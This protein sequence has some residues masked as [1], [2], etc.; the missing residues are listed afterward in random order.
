MLY[1]AADNEDEQDE[2]EESG[3]N[4]S[5]DTPEE[6]QSPAPIDTGSPQPAPPLNP[7]VAS[8]LQQIQQAH[9]QRLKNEQASDLTAALAQLTHGLSR[10]PGS[11]DL[12]GAQALAKS[13]DDPIK[14]V[15]ENHQ[16]SQY[17][18]NS[19]ESVAFRNT[20]KANFPKIAQAYGDQFDGLTASDAPQI[21][22]FAELKDTL[23]QRGQ[24]AKDRLASIEVQKQANALR[25]Q[26]IQSEKMS[27]QDE[28]TQAK[29][30]GELNSLTASGRNALGLAS[31]ARVAAQ[32]L[33]DIVN[34][35]NATNQ[36]LQSA[37]ADL[38]QIVSGAATVSGSE[39]QSYNTAFG[40]LSKA[41]TYIT[42]NPQAPDIPEIKKHVG[43]VADRMSNISDRVIANNTLMTQA[44]HS[45]WIK[46]H[47][48]QWAN[49]VRASTMGDDSKPQ[50]APNAPQS[51]APSSYGA[52][53]APV[54]QNGHTYYWNPKTNKYE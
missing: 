37:Y 14:Q 2:S 21:L 52:V 16:A 36:D 7:A 23:A 25:S 17:D 31:K 49:M 34:D 50:A 18:P 35:P 29:I 40:D 30:G 3:A 38:N 28:D 32:R 46:R 11:A 13:S 42:G 15:E 20:I 33:K 51:E 53:H 9:Q 24:T 4:E 43:Q 19:Q 10:A 5:G 54:T 6:K 41:L 44:R 45:E 39:H 47:P 12:S 26:E 8:Y 22:K 1:D 27:K 48:E